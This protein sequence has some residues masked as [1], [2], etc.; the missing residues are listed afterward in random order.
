M[1]KKRTSR[2]GGMASSLHIKRNTA[3]TSNELSLSVMDAL[4]SK[5]DEISGVPVSKGAPGGI[6]LFTFPDKTVGDPTPSNTNFIPGT[7]GKPTSSSAHASAKGS[8]KNAV[9]PKYSAA[10]IAGLALEMSN[11]PEVKKAR[12]AA[13]I[14]NPEAEIARRK[15]RRRVR[16]VMG[17]ALG[18]V[19]SVAVVFIMGSY[20]LKNYDDHIDQLSLLHDGM[21]KL[22]QADEVIVRM[23][24]IIASPVDPE[25]VDEIGAVTADLETA[26]Q[27]LDDAEALARQAGEGMSD[28]NDKEAANRVVA[29]VDARR[30]MV[31]NAESIMAADVDASAAAALV[32]DAWETILDAD[33]L[34]RDA[35]A[36][37]ENTT[38]ENTRQS[39]GKT[40]QA[41]ALFQQAKETLADASARYASADLSLLTGYLDKRIEALGYALA[42]DQAIYIQDKKTAD[43]QNALYNQAD[44]EAAKIAEGLP[45]NP[46]QPIADAYEAAI[47]PV[48][49]KY[50]EARDRAGTADAFLRE[51]LGE[52]G[53]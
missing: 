40:Q 50:K 32:E 23:D 4:S 31:S 52:S 51:Y 41:L 38:P 22:E 43:T 27:Y 46:T 17:T 9:K 47:K 36:L 49:Q 8:R 48:L 19:A 33:A 5:A 24:G 30:D 42:S 11:N 14:E 3:G 53:E 13:A 44:A 34:S 12:R 45:E 35:A 16:R 28:S 39:E 7:N 1:N 26:R 6:S 15:T 10:D 20:L 2:F 25:S 18:V 29:A 21:G 37:I